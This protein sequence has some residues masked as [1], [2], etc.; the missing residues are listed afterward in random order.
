MLILKFPRCSV[1]GLRLLY[2]VVTNNWTAMPCLTSL[3]S[4]CYYLYRL[5]CHQL[6]SS[7]MAYFDCLIGVNRDTA[8]KPSPVHRYPSW[9]RV[10]WRVDCCAREV[11]TCS[12]ALRCHVS[13]SMLVH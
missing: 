12:R 8:A 2:E 3:S 6:S 1:E 10:D 7:L 11:N 13:Y 9:I 5:C 4:Y